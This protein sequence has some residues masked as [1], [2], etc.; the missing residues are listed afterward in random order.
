LARKAYQGE[1]PFDR[2]H[3]PGA[4]DSIQAFNH[5]LQRKRSHLLRVPAIEQSVVSLHHYAL[6]L[7]I[8]EFVIG[9]LLVDSLHKGIRGDHFLPCPSC[10]LA[11]EHLECPQINPSLDPT[12][13]IDLY[14]RL[15]ELV[16]RKRGVATTI[17]RRVLGLGR[18][19]CRKVMIVHHSQG[20]F[21]EFADVLQ[22]PNSG[23]LGEF[24]N[25]VGNDC[26]KSFSFILNGIVRDDVE[27][28][29]GDDE[30]FLEICDCAYSR[31][32]VVGMC[33]LAN[34]GK[35]ASHEID[36]HAVVRDF[37]KLFPVDLEYS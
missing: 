36:E 8:E 28:P 10:D 11:D 25:L 5:V 34:G 33:R 27:F 2:L 26:S 6:D 35:V 31:V 32:W 19:D 15:I 7:P 9:N 16:A 4:H 29:E 23:S 20:L 12:L 18:T 13:R 17:G 3:E 22:V 1:E 30:Q 21:I 14:S 37:E 24:F